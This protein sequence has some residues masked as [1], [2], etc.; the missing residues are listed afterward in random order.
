MDP[1]QINDLQLG[2]Q[3]NESKSLKNEDESGEKSSRA[4]NEVNY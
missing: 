1:G 3:E 2:E 4:L